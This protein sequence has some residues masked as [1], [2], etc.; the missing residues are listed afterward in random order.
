MPLSLSYKELCCRGKQLSSRVP[1]LKQTVI[2]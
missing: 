1:A 2:F